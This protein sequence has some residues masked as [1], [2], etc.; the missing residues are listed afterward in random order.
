MLT[1]LP[2]LCLISWNWHLY[3][4]SF[5]LSWGKFWMLLPTF[6]RQ[7]SWD[8]CHQFSYI[9]SILHNISSMIF[10]SKKRN[11]VDPYKKLSKIPEIWHLV[12]C[13]RISFYSNLEYF[14]SNNEVLFLV[15][16]EKQ[17]KVVIGNNKRTCQT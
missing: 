9:W 7:Y 2:T 11:C 12:Y 15:N 14:Q 10:Y 13:D 5:G 8:I 3:K 16:C 17:A 1:F 4:T 6:S